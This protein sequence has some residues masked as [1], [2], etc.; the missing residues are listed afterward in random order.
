MKNPN[1]LPDISVIYEDENYLVI[2]KPA[3]LVV[4]SD[5]RTDEPSVAGWVKEKFP[6]ME[7]I[8]GEFELNSG[9]AVKRCG[10]VHRIDRET[11]GVLA[12][13]K[14]S[15]AFL[16]LRKQFDERQVRKIYRAFV[17][18]NIKEEFGTVDRPIGK[19]NKDFRQWSAQRGA[20][21]TLRE[22]VTDFRVLAR[23]EDATFLEAEPKTGRTH[24]IRVHFKAVNHPVVADSLYAPKMAPISGFKRLALHAFSLEFRGVAGE[25]IKAE[26]PYPGDFKN[27]VKEIES[28]SRVANRESL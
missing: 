8:G 10:I 28:V 23:S 18:G 2:N 4:H 12:I 11:S 21:G 7:N 26:A 27:A 5:G 20:K 19:S 6:E 14:N 22:A 9:E 16:K 25:K 3:G 15:E 1:N 13:A 24:Q 17:Y